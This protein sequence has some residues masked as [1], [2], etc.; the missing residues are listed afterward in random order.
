LCGW[1]LKETKEAIWLYSMKTEYPVE[2]SR[3]FELSSEGYH[4]YWC[5][6]KKNI[7]RLEEIEL[8]KE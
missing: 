4:A 5:I 6:L 1:I 2:L 8:K 7:V 3:Q